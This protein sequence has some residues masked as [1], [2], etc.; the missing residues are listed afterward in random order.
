MIGHET[1]IRDSSR[2]GGT[3]LGCVRKAAAEKLPKELKG[4]ATL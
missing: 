3:D 1:T 2:Y 4:F